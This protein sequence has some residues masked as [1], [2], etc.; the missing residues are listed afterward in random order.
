M[1]RCMI[2]GNTESFGS[3]KLEPVAPTANSI[4]TALLANFD[5]EGYID[6]MENMGA[7][8]DEAQEAW[9][10][11]EVYFDFCAFCGAKEI[12]WP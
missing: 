11:P 1:P 4:P 5:N 2:C 8:L 6:N 9:E 10:E 7:Q 12:Q 3:S